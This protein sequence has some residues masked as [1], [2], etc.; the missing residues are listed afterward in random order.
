MSF[1]YLQVWAHKEERIQRISKIRQRL[2]EKN[3]PQPVSFAAN[4][5]LQNKDFTLN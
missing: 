1:C 5:I 4:L 2:F 3:R